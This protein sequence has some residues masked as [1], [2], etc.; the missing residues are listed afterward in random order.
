MVRLRERQQG[1]P[2]GAGFLF[3]S[4]LFRAYL[5]QDRRVLLSRPLRAT[6]DRTIQTLAHLLRNLLLGSNSRQVGRHRMLAG[7]DV[8]LNLSRDRSTCRLSSG[9]RTW[10]AYAG[11]IDS[12]SDLPVEHQ[13]RPLADVSVWRSETQPAKGPKLKNDDQRSSPPAGADDPSPAPGRTASPAR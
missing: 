10:T 9:Q 11:R 6:E 4:L 7:R 8:R 2:F 12:E 1:P 5:D 13:R 3:F